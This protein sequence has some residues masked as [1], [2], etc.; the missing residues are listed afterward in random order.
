[1]AEVRLLLRILDFDLMR[2]C[3]SSSKPATAESR[4][5]P[6]ADARASIVNSLGHFAIFEMR[7]FPMTAKT[8][9]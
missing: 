3:G 5:N 7:D 8:P 2:I 9:N 6:R 1:M 4:H